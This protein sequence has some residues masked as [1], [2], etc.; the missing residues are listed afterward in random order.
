[1]DAVRPI[2]ELPTERQISWIRK[3]VA[4]LALLLDDDRFEHSTVAAD[5]REE[6]Q[7]AG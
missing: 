5:A 4:E 7:A 6:L 3:R 2:I 1:M